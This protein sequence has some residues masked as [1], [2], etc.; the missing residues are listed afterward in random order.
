VKE[1]VIVRVAP[2]KQ[3]KNWQVIRENDKV[4]RGKG[5]TK[6]KAL[7]LAKKLA[8]RNARPAIVLIHKTRYIIDR[9]LQFGGA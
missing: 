2:D 7:K 5:M 8:E 6:K 3:L 4:P 1:L 9:S